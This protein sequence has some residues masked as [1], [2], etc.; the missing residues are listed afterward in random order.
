[1]LDDEMNKSFRALVQ[2]EALKEDMDKEAFIKWMIEGWQEKEKAIPPAPK[3]SCELK[4]R[5]C[6]D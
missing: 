3:N 6:A 2:H 1:M 5:N 4:G